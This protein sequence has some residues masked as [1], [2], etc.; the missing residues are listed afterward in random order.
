M[1]GETQG[2]IKKKSF[3]NNSTHNGTL[4]T[5]VTFKHPSLSDD[6]F[7]SIQLQDEG[8]TCWAEISDAEQRDYNLLRETNSQETLTLKIRDPLSTFQPKN[9]DVVIVNDQR[10]NNELW[11]VINIKPDFYNRKFLTVTLAK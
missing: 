10:H 2:M 5:L 9:S 3:K 11:N 4:R 7:E 1:K 6:V 8:Y